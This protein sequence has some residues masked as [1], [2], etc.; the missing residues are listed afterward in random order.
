MLYERKL[1]GYSKPARPAKPD[2]N[3]PL[4]CCFSSLGVDG[5]TL[6]LL[7]QLMA[8][9]KCNNAAR[10]DRDGFAGAG[11][12]PGPR[13]LGADL[14]IAEAGNLHIVAFDQAV[15][16]QVEERVDHVL[17]FALVQPDLLEQEL[18][19]LRLGQRG[20]FQAFDGEVHDVLLLHCFCGRG[21]GYPLKRP[22]S[23]LAIRPTTALTT[24]SI[25]SSVSVASLLASVKR[26][27]RLFSSAARPAAACLGLYRSNR[28][29]SRS[30]SPVAADRT[31]SSTAS[32][33][34]VSL[35]L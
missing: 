21:H 29:A 13:R 34:T 6:D 9:V 18:R 17:G 7:F 32:W 20:R 30:S 4:N 2:R 25:C 27:A 22:P 23:W 14:K 19:Q 15:G 33:V 5:V 31:A 8:G 26:T 24:P 1:L 3:L 10:L 35:S 12:A 16:D 28:N 11:V